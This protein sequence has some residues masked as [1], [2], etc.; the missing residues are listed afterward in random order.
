MNNESFLI[1]LHLNF[2]ERN[3]RMIERFTQERQRFKENSSS[4]IMLLH[5]VVKMEL[6]ESSDIIVETAFNIVDTEYLI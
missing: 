5:A 1:L 4:K 2:N 6:I 3:I